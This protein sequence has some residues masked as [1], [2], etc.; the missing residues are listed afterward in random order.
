[1]S[2]KGN[3]VFVPKLDAVAAVL[4]AFKLAAMSGEL[5]AALAGA[6]KRK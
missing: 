4:D 1:L 5:D 2:D 6:S 3:A